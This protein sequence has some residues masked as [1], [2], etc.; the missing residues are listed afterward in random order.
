MK[1]QSFAII[2]GFGLVLRASSGAA[3]IPAPT[4]L[5]LDELR[6]AMLARPVGSIT[7][8]ATSGSIEIAGLPGR[9]Q[10]WD[11]VR[12]ARFRTAIDAGAMSGS[13]GWDGKNAWSQDY[14]GLTTIDRGTFGRMAAI[15]QSYLAN[16]RYLRPDAGGATVVY[17]GERSDNGLRY[18]VLAVTPPDGTEIDLWL[19][20]RTHLIERETAAI[21]IVSQTTVLSNYRRVEGVTYPFATTVQTSTGNSLSLHLS[22]LRINGEVSD[23]IRVPQSDVH[24]FT[25]SGGESTTVPFELINNH[26]YLDDVMLDGHG[27]YRF[28]LDSGGDY[29]VTPQVAASLGSKTAGAL[30][31][32]GVGDATEGAAFAHIGQLTVGNAV[33]H[34][35][36]TLVLPIATSFGVAE[37]LHIDGMVGYQF[38]ARFLTTIEY[39]NAK[40]TLSLPPGAPPASTGAA[41]IPF[42]IDGSIP[43]IDV[44]VDGVPASAEVDTGNRAGLELSSPFIAT[45]P[46][47]AALAKTQPGVVGFGVGGPAFARLGRVPTLQIGPYSIANS[48]ASFSS[49]SNGALADPFNPVNIGGAI[50]RRFDVTF[51]YARQ[52][53][54]LTKNEG[55]AAPFSYDRSGLFL[56]D[57]GGA[58]TVLSV[59][60]GTPAAAAGLAKGDVVIAVNGAPASNDSLAALRALL[61]GPT[62]TVVRLRI[63]GPGGRE[64]ESTLTLSDYV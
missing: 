62:G 11:D 21:G 39:A 9:V 16:L 60:P 15:D 30:R 59:F 63:R 35:Q 44:V 45:H 17:G 19:D 31:L 14:A 56:I 32:Q 54:V 28:V 22:A 3:E 58:H 37:G 38:L 23:R 18:D 25:I 50:W 34:N 57:A 49:Q 36:Y 12:A 1:T 47:L 41:V 7:S 24:D 27:P 4:K 48:V 46:A 8:I 51:D 43:R 61:S 33:I 26:V 40:I 10:E 6:K 5:L 53:L 20:P 29:I 52:Q 13:N 2:L 64:R 55:F 42:S